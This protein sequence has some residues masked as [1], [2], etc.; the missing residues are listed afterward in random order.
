MHSSVGVQQARE[1]LPRK[2]PGVDLHF[3]QP[4]ERQNAAVRFRRVIALCEVIADLL[5]ITAAVSLGYAI[6]NA[7]ALGKHI[8]Y[9]AKAVVALAFVFAIV[10]VLM[11]DRV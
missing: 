5:T 10:M 2:L 9:P 11:L 6:Y 1:P 4:S 8:Y 3:V 7:F